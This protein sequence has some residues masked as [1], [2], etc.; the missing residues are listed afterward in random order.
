[1]GVEDAGDWGDGMPTLLIGTSGWDYNHWKEVFYPEDLGRGDWFGYYAERFDTVEVNNSFYRLPPR[2]LFAQWRRQAPEGFVYTVKA[3]RYITHVKK[4]SDPSRGIRN[5]YHNLDGM[6]DRCACVLFQLPPRFHSNPAR[7][8]DF[9][10]QVPKRHRIAMEFR[11][12]T[13]MSPEIDGIL[14]EHGAALCAADSPFYP[15][16]DHK[17]AGFDFFRMHGGRQRE[18]PGYSSGELRSLARKIEGRLSEGR[19]VFVYFNNDYAGHAVKDATRL[20]AMLVGR[21]PEGSA[22]PPE[23]RS[24]ERV[25]A[26]AGVAGRGG[27]KKVH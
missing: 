20:K 4:L 27:E 9:L 8:A 24:G 5:F 14:S 13:W 10:R 25:G 3:S 21:L 6:G 7:L 18:A 19:D 23:S 26:G 17:T 16:P 12:E 11:D 15:A 1:M 2:E 22:S